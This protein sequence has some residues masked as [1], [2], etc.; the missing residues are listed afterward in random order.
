MDVISPPSVVEMESFI[1]GA[2]IC[3][4]HMERLYLGQA[5]MARTFLGG[6]GRVF[7]VK[8]IVHHFRGI[9]IHF[10]KNI[11]D[12]SDTGYYIQGYGR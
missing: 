12:K 4:D 10:S 2:V 1:L 7:W 3:S 6:I 5:F 9:F 8:T 11:L